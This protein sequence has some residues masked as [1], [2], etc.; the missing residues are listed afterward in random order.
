MLAT[1]YHASL[2]TNVFYT[3]YPALFAGSAPL[4]A[5]L[6]IR[7][8]AMMAES[9][10]EIMC[11]YHPTC[12]G[13]YL[14]GTLRRPQSENTP[15][16]R[17][18][19]VV[20]A[21][22]KLIYDQSPW[23]KTSIDNIFYNVLGFVDNESRN[24]TT[25]IGIGNHIAD[26]IIAARHEDGCNQ[27]GTRYDMEESHRL[28]YP[29]V[30]FT[31]YTGYA[32]V[33]EWNRIVDP[34]R[35]QPL[36]GVDSKFRPVSQV[37]FLMQIQHLK[38]WANDIS[39]TYVPPLTN[40]WD[41]HRGKYIAKVNHIIEVQ[42]NLT[43][44]QKLLA[45]FY[46]NKLKS[47][48][49]IGE[50]V[51]AKF[52]GGSLDNHTLL[53]FILHG[54]MHESMAA[55]WK[56]KSVYDGVRPFTAV[57]FVKGDKMIKGLGVPGKGI[58]NIRG[59]EWRSYLNTDSFSSYPSGTSSICGTFTNA[60]R[61]LMGTNIIDFSYTFPAGSSVFEPNVTPAQ[62]LTVTYHTLDEIAYDCKESRV[63]AGVHFPDDSNFGVELGKPIGTRFHAKT[64][65]AL[66]GQD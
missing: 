14:K 38:T 21:A 18:V 47:L 25:P 65:R 40:T 9:R 63:W 45:E 23:A 12:K 16:N 41:K 42:K 37:N 48:N 64:M 13:K 60:I 59:R 29:V 11:V 66:Q 10:M 62:D 61:L 43:E 27:L 49:T 28:K 54:A 34:D 6:Q 44:K 7:W 35:W 4:V 30:N 26:T 58:V 8:I 57:H 31:D 50:F 56:W 52:M 55:C 15:Y 24:L 5:P 36:L 3:L 22:R 20:Y 19:A 1:A 39:N 53:N 32:P 46:D 17:N 51:V 33:N 2:D